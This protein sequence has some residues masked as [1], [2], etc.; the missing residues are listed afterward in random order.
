M[1]SVVNAVSRTAPNSLGVRETGPIDPIPPDTPTTIYVPPGDDDMAD[2]Q[3]G[4]RKEPTIFPKSQSRPP[5][6]LTQFSQRS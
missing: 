3:G 4:V 6:S 5:M 2:M 1:D